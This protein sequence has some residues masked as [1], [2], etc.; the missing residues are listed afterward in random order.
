MTDGASKAVRDGPQRLVNAAGG[1]AAAPPGPA[2][3]AQRRG[4]DA[5]RLATCA[6]LGVFV[7]LLLAASA[8]YPGGSWTAPG[9]SGFSISR[10]FWCDLLR[11]QAING[12][13]NARAKQLASVAFTALGVGL[14]PYWWVAAAVLPGVRRRRVLQLGT[15]S[16]ACLAAMAL[17]PS[18]RFPVAHGGVALIGGALGMWATGVSV[19]TRLQAEP[20]IGWRRTAGALLL[21]FAASNALLYIYVAYLR[22]PETVAQPI[23]QKLATLALLVWMLSTVR[24]ARRL[25]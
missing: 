8:S 22:G 15:A 17:L 1:H 10:N 7:V 16:A 12:V 21:V 14:W 24:Q 19:G 25:F 23:V 20:R 6:A 5:A 18:D 9:E 4:R 2:S 3:L 13:D 11:S